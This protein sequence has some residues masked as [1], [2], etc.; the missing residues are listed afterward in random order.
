MAIKSNARSS[1]A[2]DQPAESLVDVT[3]GQMDPGKLDW[4]HVPVA[5]KIPQLLEHLERRFFLPSKANA[6]PSAPCM[7]GAWG[8]K[9]TAR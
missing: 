6:R 4:R 3:K 8:D 5:G 2:F 7:R 1:Q 9:C